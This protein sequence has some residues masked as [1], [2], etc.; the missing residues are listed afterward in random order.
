MSQ[1]KRKLAT[2]E[3]TRVKERDAFRAQLAVAKGTEKQL[4]QTIRAKNTELGQAQRLVAKLQQQRDEARAAVSST[5]SMPAHVA[6][7]ATTSVATAT[8]RVAPT[9]TT[10]VWPAS[11]LDAP[12]RSGR[13]VG[14]ISLCDGTTLAD[15][16][17]VAAASGTRGSDPP[18]DVEAQILGAASAAELRALFARSRVPVRGFPLSNHLSDIRASAAVVTPPRSASPASVTTTHTVLGLPDTPPGEDMPDMDMDDDNGEDDV[19]EKK[20]RVPGDDGDDDDDDG[21]DGEEEEEEEEAAMVD[22][23][24]HE[25]S[26]IR[27]GVGARQ[28]HQQPTEAPTTK[29]AAVSIAKAVIA[30]RAT[31]ASKVSA[32]RAVRRGADALFADLDDLAPVPTLDAPSSLGDV[33]VAGIPLRRFVAGAGS[34]ATSSNGAGVVGSSVAPQ[35]MGV[36]ANAHKRRRLTAPLPTH[37]STELQK[38]RDETVAAFV[39]RTAEVLLSRCELETVDKVV[40]VWAAELSCGDPDELCTALHTFVRQSQQ[41]KAFESSSWSSH[42]CSTSKEPW[43]DGEAHLAR[44]I[45]AVAK[46][47]MSMRRAAAEGSG[48]GDGDGGGRGHGG[49]GRG[50]ALC[51]TLL[52]FFSFL[53]SSSREPLTTERGAWARVVRVFGAVCKALGRIDH[54][55]AFCV[56]QLSPHRTFDPL[57]LLTFV[58]ACPDA[59][60]VNDAVD[61]SAPMARITTSAD[62]AML[63]IQLCVYSKLTAS[64]RQSLAPAVAMDRL[65]QLCG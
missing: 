38:G 27:H 59:L 58:G 18:P 10:T 2:V 21:D 43:L 63:A 41:L 57:L 4:Q 39:L 7:T 30:P 45:F 12:L 53:L 32:R 49:R 44:A 28:L 51:D 36:T 3:A 65:M 50:A 16:A 35:A 47:A 33:L 8:E 26:S 29:G 11:L 61:L 20:K 13:V 60:K 55:K 15:A 9:P 54:A 34:G 31:S 24:R 42:A 25:P 6:V 14:D 1:L 40:A 46:G 37:A 5:T 48:G 17:R 56:D 23:A 62:V 64:G 52:E 22:V 19:E